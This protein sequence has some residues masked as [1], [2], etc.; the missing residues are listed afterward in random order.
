MDDQPMSKCQNHKESNWP[1]NA[2]VQTYIQKD[3]KTK[4]MQLNRTDNGCPILWGGMDKVEWNHQVGL[5]LKQIAQSSS[6]TGQKMPGE[7][8]IKMYPFAK[9]VPGY[10]GYPPISCIQK[11]EADADGSCKCGDC[12]SYDETNQCT[13]CN[14]VKGTG[15]WICGQ[16]W[17][18]PDLVGGGWNNGYGTKAV[19][20]AY[21]K[22]DRNTL[23]AG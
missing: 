6:A 16:F 17:E 5:A 7:S 14:A 10:K 21:N 13:R 1:D 20:G 22:V 8:K 15:E 12:K 2:V 3:A 9:F 4:V 18:N 11:C 23:Q 19:T